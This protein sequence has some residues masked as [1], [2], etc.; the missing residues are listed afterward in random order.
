VTIDLNSLRGIL[1]SEQ[2]VAGPPRYT[3]WSWPVAMA[4]AAAVAKLAPLVIAGG[5]GVPM[6]GHAAREGLR[7]FLER[8]GV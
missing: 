8:L 6:T 5:H 3:S 1:L 4:S 2:R 7:E